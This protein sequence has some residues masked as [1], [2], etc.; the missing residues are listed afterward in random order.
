[1]EFVCEAIIF[2]LDGVLVDSRAL[3]E[4]HRRRWAAEHNI[5]FEEI[6]DVYHGRS[7][8]DVIREVA[9]HLDAETA[10]RRAGD[11]VIGVA[12]TS[13]AD[14]LS[15]ADLVIKRLTDLNVDASDPETV[16]VA[17]E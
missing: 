11:Q 4:R 2:D 6:E 13:P 12:D 10:A 9:P 8:A 16:Q 17:T 14:S 15:D 3:I 5:P 1:M 7:S